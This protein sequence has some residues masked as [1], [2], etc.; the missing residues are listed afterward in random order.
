M[1][2]FIVLGLVFS[3]PSQKIGLE[4]RT[5]MY[6][7][8]ARIPHV[9]EAFWRG[10]ILRMPRITC[11]RYFERYL[12][13]GKSDAASGYQST[14]ATYVLTY[15]MQTG[16]GDEA[17]RFLFGRA[18]R[19]VVERDRTYVS[20][21]SAPRHPKTTIADIFPQLGLGCRIIEFGFMVRIMGY[22]WGLGLCFCSHTVRRYGFRIFLLGFRARL[23]LNLEFTV[24]ICD[25]IVYSNRSNMGSTESGT[26][27][28]AYTTALLF[29]CALE[30]H[31][32][33]LLL[34]LL[35]SKF[36]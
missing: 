10:V 15:L 20:R 25:S 34:Y 28:N 24:R 19:L 32:V 11:G 18:R 6:Y 21:S 5:C 26:V 17:V 36:H 7:A 1:R 31:L 22:G 8:G 30:A 16:P 4:K 9:N 35:M 3:I 14:V 23:R 29:S 33:Y 13:R 27:S 12:L 2:A